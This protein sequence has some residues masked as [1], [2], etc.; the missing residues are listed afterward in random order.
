M[1]NLAVFGSINFNPTFPLSHSRSLFLL[2]LTH[3]L[4]YVMGSKHA[5]VLCKCKFL[6][7]FCSNYSDTLQQI[8]CL[9]FFHSCCRNK[10]YLGGCHIS[11]VNAKH[12]VI[13]HY[14]AFKFVGLLPCKEEKKRNCIGQ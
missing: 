8:C 2:E 1:L 5:L 7:W 12:S 10:A 6:Y 9:T 14:M 4:Q 3:V 13:G 11:L